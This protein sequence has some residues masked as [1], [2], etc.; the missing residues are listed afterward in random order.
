MIEAGSSFDNQL[1]ENYGFL[2]EPEMIDQIR[3]H[4][5]GKKLRQGDYVMDIGDPITHVPL[6]LSGAIKIVR[7]DKNG[8]EILLYYIES[9][10]TCAFSLS[11][12]M[13]RKK[14]E[15]RAMAEDETS[16]IMLPASLMDE[17]V[18]KFRSWRDFIFQ[19]YNL[20]L[21]EMLSTIESIAFMRMDERLL[22]YLSDKTKVTGNPI[23]TNTHQE[24]AQDLNT[25]RVVISRLVKQ[26]EKNGTIAQHRGSI[27]LLKF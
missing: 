25:S 18:V 4:G 1:T 13:G 9:G 22:R 23:L 2:L 17:W 19:S 14:S 15:I 26:L 12:C 5:T 3:I 21:N 7:E 20:R 6:M 24:I 16:M 8:Q 10:D 11:C 27:E